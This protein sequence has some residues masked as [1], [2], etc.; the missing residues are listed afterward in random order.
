MDWL[1]LI[2][3]LLCISFLNKSILVVIVVW[4][5]KKKIIIDQ[6]LEPPLYSLIYLRCDLFSLS[7]SFYYYEDVVADHALSSLKNKTGRIYYE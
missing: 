7:W 5:S 6:H 3:Q 2:Q 1:H 4:N